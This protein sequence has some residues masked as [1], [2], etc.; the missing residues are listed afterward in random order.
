MI[1]CWTII[2]NFFFFVLWFCNFGVYI[3]VYLKKCVKARQNSVNLGHQSI[4][5]NHCKLYRSSLQNQIKI[6]IGFGGESTNLLVQLI[7]QTIRTLSI[8]W[9]SCHSCKKLSRHDDTVNI[10]RSL[11]RFGTLQF[12]FIS[13]LECYTPY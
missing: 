7:D 8:L 5:K 9:L 12:F 13:L 1:F 6:S 2:S 10:S 11:S 4:K 3:C